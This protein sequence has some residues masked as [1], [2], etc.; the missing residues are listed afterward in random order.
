MSHSVAWQLLLVLHGALHWLLHVC[1]KV[2]VTI[3]QLSVNS[4]H[5]DV[6]PAKKSNVNG[7]LS[8]L[9][10]HVEING[11]L[12]EEQAIGLPLRQPCTPLHTSTPLQNKLSLHK[13][14]PSSS[15]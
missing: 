8:G 14:L 2:I 3:V 13:E 1:V 9:F 4:L 5:E 15:V 6:K 10:K 7:L 11:R 12:F